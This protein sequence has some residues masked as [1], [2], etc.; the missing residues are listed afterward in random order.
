[1][2]SNQFNTS[3]GHNPEIIYHILNRQAEFEESLTF[4]QL[5][6]ALRARGLS[7]QTRLLQQQREE[8]Q[9]ELRQDLVGFINSQDPISFD[10]LE[11]EFNN[12]AVSIFSL[13]S[14]ESEDDGIPFRNVFVKHEQ[15]MSRLNTRTSSDLG[16]DTD[17]LL[18]GDYM[19]KTHLICDAHSIVKFMTGPDGKHQIFNQAFDELR[20]LRLQQG[21]RLPNMPDCRFKVKYENP[22]EPRDC[23]M[24]EII[25]RHVHLPGWSGNASENVLEP[26][27]WD[28]GIKLA[29]GR[30]LL[31]TT[32]QE[33]VPYLLTTVIEQLGVPDVVTFGEFIQRVEIKAAFRELWDN[34]VVNMHSD[35][36]LPVEEDR[37]RPVGLRIFYSRTLHGESEFDE[38]MPDKSDWDLSSHLARFCLKVEKVC[39]RELLPPMRGQIP[40]L[41][42]PVSVAVVAWGGTEIARVLR[43][44]PKSSRQRYLDTV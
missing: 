10:P 30:R 28:R 22:L 20:E 32:Y 15:L 5:D 16:D 29:R 27:E 7:L 6:A 35:L 2:E 42:G 18:R 26:V 37:R 13:G 41:P 38:D 34:A 19:H 40:V 43:R 39:N 24:V 25:L 1:M 14:T 17:E 8:Q 23:P 33:R 31:Q 12:E 11:V 9:E 21:L 36:E 3:D 44:M 4:N